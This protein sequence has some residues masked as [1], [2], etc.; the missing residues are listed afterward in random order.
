VLFYGAGALFSIGLRFVY[1]KVDYRS[2]TI[3]SLSLVAVLA[4]VAA[5]VLWY[6]AERGLVAW[7]FPK[8][9]ASGGGWPGAFAPAK[10]PGRVFHMLWPFMMWSILYFVINFWLEWRRE[11]ERALEA[12]LLAQKAQLQMLRYQLNPHFLFNALNSIRAL[13]DENR[14]NARAM[15]TELAEFLRYSLVHRDYANV[16]LSNEMEAVHL[17]LSIQKRRYEDKLEV[18]TEVSGEAASYP[19]PCFLVHPLVENAVKYGMQ[20]SPMPL[21]LAIRAD[22]SSG[23]LRL[24]VSNTGRWVTPGP[25]REAGDPGT[26]TGLDNVRQRLDAAFPH[27]HKLEVG[28]QD[29][30]VVIG[31]ELRGRDNDHSLPGAGGAGQERLNGDR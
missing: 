23:T 18:S 29:G 8:S 9:F 6:L 2:R 20:T 12:T 11:R 7:F 17:Y 22:V 4:S 13:V 28:E 21:R 25:D 10:Y 24:T 1:R 19:V 14:E 27:R 16:P 3:R 31:L 15:V 30:W 26:G 5:A